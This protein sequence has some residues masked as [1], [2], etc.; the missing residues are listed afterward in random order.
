MKTLRVLSPFL[1][2]ALCEGVLETNE[3]FKWTG[4][5]D[6]ISRAEGWELAA[7]SISNPGDSAPTAMLDPAALG[8]SPYCHFNG[9]SNYLAIKSTTG[10][11]SEPREK[12]SI[13]TRS[14]FTVSMWLR[15]MANGGAQPLLDCDRSDVRH[16]TTSHTDVASS[17]SAHPTPRTPSHALE[18][19]HRDPIN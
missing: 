12:T 13:V 6:C 16:A 15:T 19:E 18:L 17:H 5:S 3:I 8:G 7:P 1:L 10:D 2:S 11:P 4:L 9:V 14:Q